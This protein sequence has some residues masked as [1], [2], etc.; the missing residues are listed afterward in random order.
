MDKRNNYP[1]RNWV[2]LLLGIWKFCLF[3]IAMLH[4]GNSQALPPNDFYENGEQTEETTYVNLA[5]SKLTDLLGSYDSRRKENSIPGGP[6]KSIKTTLN[7]TSSFK[8]FSFTP[9]GK[10]DGSRAR[11]QCDSDEEDENK[12][13]KG[14]KDK[15]KKDKKDKG[16]KGKGKKDNEPPLIESIIQQPANAAGW[17]NSPVTISYQ[18]TDD[19]SEIDVCPAEQTLTNE[20]ADQS[21]VVEATDTAGNTASLTTNNINIDL[22]SPTVTAQASPAVNANG[23]YNT[24]VTV[25]FDCQDTLSGI[26]TCP[27]PVNVTVEGADQVVQG[28]GVDLAGN[29]QTVSLTV[30]IDQTPPTLQITQPVDNAI[31][32]VL[33]PQIE[34]S[35]ADN[36]SL[37]ESSLVVTLNNS[38]FDGNC[39]L[40][41]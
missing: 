37:D 33:R 9:I 15:G 23:W 7:S 3:F 14:K 40:V 39:S 20:G 32:S 27:S 36:L 11:Y 19:L 21:I 41:V 24:S 38:P 28:T 31:V 12:K 29:S 2:V 34:L 6:G 4:V 10:D 26:E 35:V 13:N 25:S 1:V 30:N 8:N 18:C 22:T 5:N 17:H 16:K